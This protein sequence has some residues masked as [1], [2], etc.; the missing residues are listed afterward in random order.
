MAMLC[1][2][3]GTEATIGIIT[4]LILSEV[5]SLFTGVHLLVCF[6]QYTATPD[7]SSS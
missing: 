4:L 2:F 6:T 5:I 3:I 1:I 7:F